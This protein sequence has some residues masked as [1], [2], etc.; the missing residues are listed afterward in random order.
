VETL[1]KVA[2][3]THVHGVVIVKSPVCT[4]VVRP[5]PFK[6]A[7]TIRDGASCSPVGNRDRRWTR[8]RQIL[9]EEPEKFYKPRLIKQAFR[10]FAGQGLLTSDGPMW[11]AFRDTPSLPFGGG[12]RVCIGNGFAMMEARL[13]LATMVQRCRL[14]VEPGQD[15][16]PMQLVT[17]RP[18]AR[19]QDKSGRPGTRQSLA[20]KGDGQVCGVYSRHLS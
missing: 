4:E 18:K 6:G 20:S 14:S 3:E 19:D 10:A 17:G 2:P 7:A 1:W 9:V 12:P 16:V 5:L 15:I 13:I 11:S 8:A